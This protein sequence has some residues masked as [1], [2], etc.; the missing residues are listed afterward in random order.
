MEYQRI[1]EVFEDKD[2]K[3]F[4]TILLNGP[5]DSVKMKLKVLKEQGTKFHGVFRSVFHFLST[6]KTLNSSEFVDWCAC[7]YSSSDR[8]IMDVTKSKILCPISPLVV[9]NT[10][11]MF[12][13]NS[14]RCLKILIKKV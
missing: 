11:F 1:E 14:P 10:F 6:K 3:V 7:N 4:D 8:G 13:L 5:I 12:L 9:L 2:S